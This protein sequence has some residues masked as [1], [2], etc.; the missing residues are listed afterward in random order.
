MLTEGV[1]FPRAKTAMIT[2]Q[3]TSNILMTQ[4]IG[5]VLRG[6]KAGGGEDKSYA[7][8]VF[9]YDTWKRLLPWVTVD[10]DGL[11]A[12]RPVAQGRNPMTL[13]SIQLLKLAASDIEYKGWDVENIPFLTFIPVGFFSCGYTA[14]VSEGTA[15]ELVSF[16]ENI[17]VYEFNRKGYDKILDS[18]SGEDLSPYAAENLPDDA[19]MKKAEE[20]TGRFFNLPKDDFD[21]QLLDNIV[22]IVRHMAQNG[23][24]PMFIDFDERD[25]YDLDKLAERLLGFAGLDAHNY[26]KNIFN[27]EGLYWK[28]FYKTFIQFFG[29]YQKSQ[30]RVL[31]KGE[32]KPPE[33]PSHSPIPLSVLTPETKAQIFKRDNYTCLCCGKTKSVTTRGL[34]IDHIKPISMGGTDDISNLQTLCKNCNQLKRQDTID[35]RVNTTPLHRAKP[36][37]NLY[38]PGNNDTLDNIV[39]RIVNDFYHCKAMRK[40]INHAGHDGQYSFTYSTWE[41][42]LYR[43]NDPNWLKSHEKA[44]REYLEKFGFNHI[45]QI[46]VSVE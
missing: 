9:F 27:D 38:P 36:H 7:N 11:D 13:V 43:G 12:E 17:V 32:D 10:E 18:L 41:I 34:N 15:E 33:P 6:E 16:A 20:L 3:T 8:I 39:A 31:I 14:S 1:D 25:V 19:L 45:S 2:R 5:R 46:D 4:M 22:K 35:Y 29:A 37:L 40:W 24:K 21:G 44:F 23:E 28:F 26:L 30:M 42:V